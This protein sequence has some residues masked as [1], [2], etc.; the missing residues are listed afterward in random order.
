MYPAIRLAVEIDVG[1]LQTSDDRL[2]FPEIE[3]APEWH[4]NHGRKGRKSMST[5]TAI[6][7]SALTPYCPKTQT[8]SSCPPV[9]FVTCS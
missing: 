3:S 6:A 7:A 4:R 8:C 1:G 2:S 9:T 5:F